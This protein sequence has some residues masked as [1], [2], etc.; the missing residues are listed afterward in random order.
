MRPALLLALLIAAASA[1]AE[2]YRW[3]DADGRVHFSDRPVD[4]AQQIALK[5]AR[6]MQAQPE[7]PR[8]TGDPGPYSAFEVVAPEA[9]A[10]LYDADGKAQVSLLIDPAL[11]QGH[12]LQVVVNGQPLPGEVKGTQMQMQGLPFGSHRLSAE[13]IDG[14]GVPVAYTPP[15]DFHLRKPE[16]ESATP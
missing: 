10:T 15:V 3:V 13:I 11:Q 12:R 4:G 5:K 2:V 7:T 9:N 6:E 16:P 14:F 8:P 1:S